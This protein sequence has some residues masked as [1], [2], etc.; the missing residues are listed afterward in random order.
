MLSQG[1]GLRPEQRKEG[2]KKGCDGGWPDGR[3]GCGEL[4]RE[5]CRGRD[6]S[7]G[8]GGVCSNKQQIDS[9]ERCVWLWR[10]ASLVGLRWVPAGRMA[11]GKK[12]NRGKKVNKK[13][14]GQA[15]GNWG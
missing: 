3:G 5:G 12:K 9:R 14:Q 15:G 11:C 7:V 1:T 8:A 10:R 13:P 2:K 4:S 6:V